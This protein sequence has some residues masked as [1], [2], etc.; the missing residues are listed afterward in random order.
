MDDRITRILKLVAIVLAVSFLGW[1]AYEKF[2]AE[3]APGDMAYHAGNRAF[4]DGNY[5]RAAAEFQSALAEDPDHVHA[6]RGLA[7]SLHMAGRHDEALTS[8]QQAIAG[9]PEFGATYANRGI[10]LDT[11][12]RH[13]DALSDYTRALALEPELADGP[14]WLTRFLRNQAE[15]P[16]SI[17]DRARYLQAELIKPEDERVLRVPE[18]DAHQ[19]PYQQ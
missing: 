6:L 8:Y 1:A 12:G 10:L 18:V 19:R 14:K 16:P 9:E 3:V 4:E 13:E 11:L 7:I 17:A 15:A 5:G 2:V